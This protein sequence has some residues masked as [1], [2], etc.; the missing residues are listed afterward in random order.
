MRRECLCAV[1]LSQGQG[2]DGEKGFASKQGSGLLSSPCAAYTQTT[3]T[4]SRLQVSQALGAVVSAGIPKPA[5]MLSHLIHPSVTRILEEPSSL[6]AAPEYRC[7]CH[8]FASLQLL[9]LY[10]HHDT[11]L[12]RGCEG[13][14]LPSSR[15]SLTSSHL[16]HPLYDCPTLSIDQ[17]LLLQSDDF[18]LPIHPSI[19]MPAA[20]LRSSLSFCT[21][22][23]QTGHPCCRSA[24]PAPLPH[25]PTLCPSHTVGPWPPPL[26]PCSPGV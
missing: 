6:T 23:P 11:Y 4:T 7:R 26:L 21:A 1:Y 3:T 13:T 22:A 10:P 18:H 14:G 2:Q 8:N 25:T 24:N 17:L 15:H 12:V 5:P 20:L 9:P 16:V 19:L